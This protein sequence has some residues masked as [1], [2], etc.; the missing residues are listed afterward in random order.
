M[1]QTCRGS[2]TRIHAVR[3]LGLGLLVMAVLV[4]CR[5]EESGGEA[6]GKRMRTRLGALEDSLAAVQ[7][8]LAY[9]E[10][11][12]TDLAQRVEAQERAASAVPPPQAS[13]AVVP[14]RS[15]VEDRL[16]AMQGSI[17]AL[18]AKQGRLEQ[19]FDKMV[20]DAANPR[21]TAGHVS[22]SDFQTLKGEVAG[23]QRRISQLAGLD[24]VAAVEKELGRVVDGLPAAIRSQVPRPAS[25]GATDV[26]AG[27]ILAFDV[28][29]RSAAGKALGRRAIPEGWAACDGRGG[30]PDLR[31]RFL[32]G[33]GNGAKAGHR[34]G[35]AKI[36]PATV[37]IDTVKERSE[38]APAKGA[39]RIS[40][41]LSNSQYF[42]W[43]HPIVAK[44]THGEGE[45]RPPF[46]TITWIIKL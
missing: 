44:H 24:R 1:N 19:G 42:F 35:A 6:E 8:R 14:P 10:R 9:R 27:T 4:G 21:A 22:G 41:K 28:V 11:V 3:S 23:I 37:R 20:R 25:G 16:R 18:T 40:P 33:A 32:M 2:V 46:H 34:G 43:I 26:P 13:A 45:N 5:G 36:P 31:G 7:K 15:T 39:R 38:N 30:R 17:G 12:A 29:R